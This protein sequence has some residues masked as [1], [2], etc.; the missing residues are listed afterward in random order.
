M[1]NLPCLGFSFSFLAFVACVACV[2]CGTSSGGALPGDTSA[3]SA[4]SPASCTTAMDC[5]PAACACTAGET[6]ET[7]TVCSQGTC[8]TG[9]NASF[10]A[11][12]CDTHGGVTAVRP[13]PNVA[14]SVE[15]DAWCSKGAGLACGVTTCDRFFFC[16]VPKGSCEAATRAALQCAVD[17][18]QWECSQHGSSWS[19]GSSCPTFAELC[20]SADAGA[21][22]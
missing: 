16:G 18:G 22:H 7:A 14:A 15:C 20:V 8:G 2:A 5:N 3:T 6:V 10:C 13:H 19:V 12:V 4:T 1:R 17:K 11:A 9:G 21:A